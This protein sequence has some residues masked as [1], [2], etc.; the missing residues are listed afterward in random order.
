MHYNGRK[1]LLALI[2][3]IAFIAFE[4]AAVVYGFTTGNWEP[5]GD[6]APFLVYTAG[7]YIAGN[8]AQDFSPPKPRGE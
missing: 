2:V 4:A 3:T 1:F 7:V 5:A 6:L 8:V